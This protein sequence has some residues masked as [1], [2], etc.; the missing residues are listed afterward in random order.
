MPYID[1]VNEVLE[2]FVVHDALSANSGHDTGS[3]QAGELLAEP[4]NILPLA[5][6]KLREA[7]YPITLPF[8]LWDDTVRWILE[9]FGASFAELLELFRPTDD[10]FTVAQGSRAYGY[11]DIFVESLGMSRSEHA[12]YTDPSVLAHWYTLYGY[13][14][15]P[16][17]VQE[18]A[19]AMT[20]A[21]RL[22][23]S[24]LELAAVV[25]TGFVNPA[26]NGMVL[27]RNLDLGVETVI[28]LEDAAKRGTVP[29]HEIAA[30][31]RILAV[32]AARFVLDTVADI[33]GWLDKM[34]QG[35]DF[36]R[37]L[38]LAAPPGS[39]CNFEQTLLQYAKGRAADAIVFLRIN[40][41][42]RLWRK[43]RWSMEDVDRAL[44]LSAD[45][46]AVPDPW[47]SW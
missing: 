11:A 4:Q 21:D 35:G 6:D 26:L 42:V 2:Y 8:D 47:Q 31:D 44:E 43:L 10:L 40:L 28:W 32:K 29:K 16:A 20:L 1:I 45:A 34:W 13:E 18:L 15:E 14:S 3:A 39:A 38:L 7:R 12:L 27:L 17:A 23:L 9:H 37:V 19:S 33:H 25:D 24:Y 41:F 22:D 30:V 46:T 5:Y 36:D